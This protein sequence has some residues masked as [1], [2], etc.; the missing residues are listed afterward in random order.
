MPNFIASYL[1][2]I[3]TLG[4]KS[5]MLLIIPCLVAL[6]FIDAS[7]VKTL[8]QWLVFAPIIAGV[9]IIVSRIVFPQLNLTKL[10]EEVHGGNTASA[11]LASGLLLFVGLLI[12]ALVTWAK[13]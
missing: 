2:R 6:F 10:V 7:M 4:D 11:I 13:A 5:A 12:F 8:V 9:A 3:K 1:K